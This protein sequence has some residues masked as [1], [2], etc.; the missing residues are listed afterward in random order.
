[1]NNSNLMKL[2][3]DKSL[4]KE[5]KEYN[6]IIHFKPSKYS[7]LAEMKLQF[8]SEI[9]TYSDEKLD[10]I[11]EFLKAKMLR[12]DKAT[13]GFLPIWAAVVIALFTSS[14][15]PMLVSVFGGIGLVAILCLISHFSE[16]SIKR[17]QFYSML[18][19]LID[20]EWENRGH[21]FNDTLTKQID[22]DEVTE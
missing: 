5:M 19:E 10:F 14:I 20:K 15:D 7:S 21:T 16:T 4:K 3:D 18:L 22:I 13:S 6:A 9:S 17:L 11:Y 1:M 12:T 8:I 2:T